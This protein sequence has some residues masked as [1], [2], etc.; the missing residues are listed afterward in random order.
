[1]YH[2]KR[3]A[4]TGLS[5]IGFA[6][7]LLVHGCVKVENYGPTTSRTNP[8]AFTP[9]TV[10]RP[11]FALTASSHIAWLPEAIKFY[12]DSRINSA[13]IKGLVEQAIYQELSR[14]G[15]QITLDTSDAD[16]LLAYTAALES[17]LGDREILLG[18]GLLPGENT[19]G[20]QDGHHEKGSLIIYLINP[21]TRA[22]VWKSVIQADVKF[23]LEHKERE[24]RIQLA[25]H[26]MLSTLATKK[27]QLI[28]K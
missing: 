23:E 3:P 21:K 20:I 25:V 2:G 27:I 6:F 22:P 24:R 12:S 4:L 14:H 1:M 28:K 18:Y 10:T 11:G 26:K 15:H 7:I 5:F 17:S 19:P 13:D 9:L 16:Y 8:E